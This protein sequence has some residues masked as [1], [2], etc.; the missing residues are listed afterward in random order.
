MFVRVRPRWTSDSKLL[1]DE[2]WTFLADQHECIVLAFPKLDKNAPIPVVRAARGLS[3]T[4]NRRLLAG[5]RHALAV[6]AF[7]IQRP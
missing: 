3:L 2:T 1:Q 7:H 6:F 5:E 4:N